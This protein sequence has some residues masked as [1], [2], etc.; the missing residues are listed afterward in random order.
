MKN[1]VPESK[2]KSCSYR[3][4][5]SCGR[6]DDGS[7]EKRLQGVEGDC[8]PDGNDV[9]DETDGGCDQDSVDRNA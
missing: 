3:Q 9:D 8:G 4:Y 2:V 7:R 1:K 5:I 6:R